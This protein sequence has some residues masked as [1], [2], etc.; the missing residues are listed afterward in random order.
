MSAVVPLS[1]TRKI[2]ATRATASSGKPA[3]A[4][5]AERM[6]MAKPGTPAAPLEVRTIV[7]TSNTCCVMDR[8]IPYNC[9]MKMVATPRKMDAPSR[10]KAYPTGTTKLTIRRGTPYLSSF[11]IS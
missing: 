1:I 8:S 4:S 5:V 7:T 2:P 11:S 6:M 3:E 10:L 9:A